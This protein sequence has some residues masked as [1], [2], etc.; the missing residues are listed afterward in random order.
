MRITRTAFSALAIASLGFATPLMAHAELQ[1]STPAEGASVGA[2]RTV[3]VTFDDALVR[4]FS[5]LELVM[6]AHNMRMQLKTT[7]SRD[8]K[9][10]IGTPSGRLMKGNYRLDWMAATADGHRETGHIPFKVK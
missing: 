4:Q 9:T 1:R 7:F 5:K 2:P 3:S 10:M 8:G 6:P